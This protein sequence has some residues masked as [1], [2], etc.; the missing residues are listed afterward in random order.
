VRGVD[1][2]GLILSVNIGL[3]VGCT[4]HSS[5]SVQSCH[6]RVTVCLK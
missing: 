3:S 6:M 5:A 1:M 2:R 4:I